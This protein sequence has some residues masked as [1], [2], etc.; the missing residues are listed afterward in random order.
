[1]SNLKD[2]IS[3]EII[4][5]MKAKAKTRLNVLR[6]VKKLLIENE[7]AKKPTD[8]MDIVISYAKKTKES[9]EIYPEGAEQRIELAAEVKVLEEF[10]PKQ[11]TEDDVVAFISD[12][13]SGLDTP[14][15]G[16]IMK[17]LSPK[18][19]GQFDGKKA[20]QLVIAALK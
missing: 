7:T 3:K 17:E 4:A 11:L 14:N 13:K 15:M 8:E 19:K 1:M 10:L 12:I 5:A 6:Y 16:A 20:S 2:T 18:I 9:I